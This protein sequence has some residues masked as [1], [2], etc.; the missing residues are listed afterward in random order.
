MPCASK[1]S[2]QWWKGRCRRG[3]RTPRR[4]ALSGAELEELVKRC[5]KRAVAP[6]AARGTIGPGAIV[7]AC[8]HAIVPISVGAWQIAVACVSGRLGAAEHAYSE[9]KSHAEKDLSA[10]CDLSSV[11]CR[12]RPTRRLLSIRKRHHPHCCANSNAANPAFS[13]GIAVPCHGLT[14]SRPAPS[15]LASACTR[16]LQASRRSSPARA[17]PRNSR[18]SSLARRRAARAERAWHPLQPSPAPLP[19]PVAANLALI[20]VSA[21]K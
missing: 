12:V 7:S 2:K 17:P 9:R 8:A 10:H 19:L 5:A 3:A 21:A 18:R 13:C 16:R 1:R 11:R 6:S 15:H 14:R 4:S 20:L